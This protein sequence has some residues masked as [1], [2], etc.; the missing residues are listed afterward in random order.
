MSTDKLQQKIA[1]LAITRGGM[2]LG[3]QIAETLSGDF[4]ACKGCLRETMEWVW[5]EYSGIITIMSTGIVARIIA[6]LLENKYRDPAVVVCDEQG[7][8]AIPLVSGHLGGA[9]ELAMTIAREFKA[10]PVITTASDVLGLTAL[11]LWCRDMQLSVDP[12]TPLTSS[13]GKLVDTGILRIFSEYP[14]PKLPPDLVLTEDPFAA[15]LIISSRVQGAIKATRLYPRALAVGIGCKR[16]SSS[17]AIRETVELVC[18]EFDLAM[19]SIAVIASVELKKDEVGLLA[20]AQELGCPT[21]FYASAALNQVASSASSPIVQ[22]MTGAKAVAEPAAMLAAGSET[23]LVPKQKGDG[24]TVAI[25][26]IGDPFAEQP[27]RD[28]KN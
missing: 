24:V 11:D 27:E 17:Q 4:F 23:L 15:D 12:V 21:H 7:Q 25:A 26:E 18:N 19:Q 14:L 3:K 13:M 10:T 22:Q 2:A 28:S 9:N 1:V 16:N 8:F 20:F 6:P 5:K